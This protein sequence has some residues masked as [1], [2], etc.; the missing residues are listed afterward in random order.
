MRAGTAGVPAFDAAAAAAE[1]AVRVAARVLGAGV[2]V[3]ERESWV[4]DMAVGGGATSGGSG[5]GGVCG[6]STL[7]AN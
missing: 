7:G 3:G 2:G 4:A 6:S 5:L 1:A